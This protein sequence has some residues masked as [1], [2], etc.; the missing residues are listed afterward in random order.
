MRMRMG[1][2]LTVGL[3]VWTAPPAA[4][5]GGK[6]AV[7]LGLDAALVLQFAND[8]GTPLGPV[9]LEDA[10]A[11]VLP[12]QFVRVGYYV[13]EHGEI[14]VRTSLVSVSV[15]D[16]DATTFTIDVAYGYNF[17]TPGRPQL[18]V[19]AGGG[20]DFFSE[21]A[22]PFGEVLEALGQPPES[23][24][25]IGLGTGVGVKL[26]VHPSLSVRLE[27]DYS[28]DFEREEDFLPA[29]HNVVLRAGL[30]YFTK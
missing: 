8:I 15:G 7:E 28:Y 18:F 17:G 1:I 10:T 5:Q 21:Q 23:V 9:P 30:S 29:Q 27:G 2:A 14:E 11:V 6:G 3:L 12:L 26:P 22:H 25:R 4:A 19:G 20:I 16:F 24:A 13:G